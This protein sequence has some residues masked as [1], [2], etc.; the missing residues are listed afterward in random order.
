MK[1]KADVAVL[2]DG[3]QEPKETEVPTDQ[4]EKTIDEWVEWFRAQLKEALAKGQDVEILLGR[5]PNG[6]EFSEQT[7][8]KPNDI[9]I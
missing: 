3:W 4:V 7:P 1:I 2:N 5:K 6:Y 9:Y 8:P